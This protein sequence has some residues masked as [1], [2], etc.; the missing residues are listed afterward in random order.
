MA[1]RGSRQDNG[2][3]VKAGYISCVE[4]HERYGISHV[5][6]EPTLAVGITA[7]VQRNLGSGVGVGGYPS[8]LRYSAYIRLGGAVA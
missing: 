7:L 8:A 4:V 5:R 6:R 3:A 1:D 2:L